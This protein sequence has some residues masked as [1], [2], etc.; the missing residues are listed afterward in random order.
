MNL[1]NYYIA[2]LEKKI[3]LNLNIFYLR[4]YF[5]GSIN[6]KNSWEIIT[7]IIMEKITIVISGNSY[8]NYGS[9][10][11]FNYYGNNNNNNY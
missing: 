11:D 5:Y 4:F 9:N 7:I 8:N 10:N 3:L 6:N 1:F 2:K